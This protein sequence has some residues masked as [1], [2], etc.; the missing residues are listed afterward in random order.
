MMTE[1]SRPEWKELAEWADAQLEELPPGKCRIFR[2]WCPLATQT[3]SGTCRFENTE[4][5]HRAESICGIVA[6]VENHLQSSK[7]HKD[8]L[9]P[10]VVDNAC[11]EVINGGKYE[12]WVCDLP[13]EP[14]AKKRK[15]EHEEGRGGKAGKGGGSDLEAQMSVL[16]ASQARLTEVLSRAAGASSSSGARGSSVPTMQLLQPEM[17]ELQ[18][19]LVGG[20]GKFSPK[21]RLAEALLNA[22]KHLQRLKNVA[23]ACATAL[24]TEIS[25]L[26]DTYDRMHASQ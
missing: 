21:G 22:K 20:G 4:L 7:S 26:Q 19:D 13:A 1:E 11:I 3:C 17:P 16:V 14:P 10:A 2:S 15:A 6:V 24:D 5:P 23:A 8:V 9:S 18:L 25:A 12:M